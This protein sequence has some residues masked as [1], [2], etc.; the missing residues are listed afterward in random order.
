V[1]TARSPLNGKVMHSPLVN[2]LGA[3]LKLA[4]FPF[5]VLYGHSEAPSYLWLH[6]EIADI[7]PAQAIWGQDTW[8]TVDHIREEQGEER[9]QVLS[10]GLAGE[11]RLSSATAVVD[12]WSEGD[13]VGLGRR[14]GEMNLKA[15]AARG[16]GELEVDDPERTL[17]LCRRAMVA[18]R[19]KLEGAKGIESLVPGADL[20]EISAIR[21]R[22]IACSGCPWPC[23][24]F[25][26]YNE[27]ATVL[28]EGLKEPG[29]LISD[30]SGFQA[31]LDGGRDATDA[32]RL[33]EACCRLGLEPIATA[34]RIKGVDLEKSKSMLRSL[35]S[36]GFEV[37]GVP[38]VANATCTEVFSPFAPNGGD[39]EVIALSYVLGICPRYSAKVGLD[40]ELCAE[41]IEATTGLRKGPQELRSLAN[42]IIR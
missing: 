26:K 27:P 33:L 39:K 23:R 6:D 32:A 3:E 9:I 1:V 38:S 7:L 15:V 17:E 21:H 42:S 11:N 36:S 25:L 5:L 14:L 40:I 18:A 37:D 13:K 19:S 20:G 34:A 22:D 41:L 10:I 28:K 31:L 35:A 29:V 8:K 2:Y 16:M 4:G 30:L 24:T 12:Y